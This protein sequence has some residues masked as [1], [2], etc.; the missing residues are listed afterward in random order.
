MAVFFKSEISRIPQ[1]FL[2]GKEV[3]Y[4][5]QK[6]ADG[7]NPPLSQLWDTCHADGTFTA[8]AQQSDFVFMD[9]HVGIMIDFDTGDG[10]FS[11][12]VGMF[13]KDGVTIPEGFA[14]HTLPETEVAIGWFKGKDAAD[15]C[16]T[17]HVQTDQFLHENG[18]VS[19]NPK[20]A[21]FGEVYPIGTDENE[22]ILRYYIPCK[23]GN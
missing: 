18:Y 15:V 1:L 12:V 23:A 21:W 16:S 3:R 6:Q 22:I 9:A 20:R 14:C 19:D 7:T 5:M 8:L 11:Y 10:N 17:A 4:S 2:V 13:M